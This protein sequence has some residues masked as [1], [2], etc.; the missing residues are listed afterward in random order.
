MNE[1]GFVRRGNHFIRVPPTM[2]W[3]LI[4]G[5]WFDALNRFGHQ[6]VRFSYCPPLD[7]VAFVIDFADPPEYMEIEE[8]EWEKF[9]LHPGCLL[10]KVPPW[11]SYRYSALLNDRQFIGWKARC[12]GIPCYINHPGWI[13]DE[14]WAEGL[15]RKGK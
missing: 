3:V 10:Y 8:L 1:I 14:Y 15:M 2:E 7:P 11:V 12:A 4:D 6:M 13:E 9:I 5:P